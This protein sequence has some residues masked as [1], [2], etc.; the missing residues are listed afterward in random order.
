MKQFLA[1]VGL[2][3]SAIF[4]LMLFAILVLTSIATMELPKPKKRKDDDLPS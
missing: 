4:S 3:G 2:I 1:M